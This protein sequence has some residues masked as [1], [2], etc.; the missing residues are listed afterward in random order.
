M[1]F[2]VIWRLNVRCIGELMRDASTL[3]CKV[4]PIFNFITIVF[5]HYFCVRI[6][7][8]K[9]ETLKFWLSLNLFEWYIMKPLL[10]TEFFLICLKLRLEEHLSLIVVGFSGVKLHFDF[11]REV[12]GI[13]C[14]RGAPMKE[15]QRPRQSENALQ[16]AEM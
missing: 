8:H 13:R 15:S 6:I 9:Y 12:S 11:I 14:R 1:F 3:H 16:S 5:W 4:I 10:H 7:T 2:M